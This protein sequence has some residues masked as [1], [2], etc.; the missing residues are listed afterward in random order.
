ME[1]QDSV[2]QILQ[3]TEA[4]ADQFYRH[5]LDAHP[6]V[7]RYFQGMD[8]KR[9]A[10]QLHMALLLAAHHYVHRYPA[11][12]SYLKVLGHTHAARRGV[13]VEAYDSFRDCLIETLAEFHGKDWDEQLATQWREA[14]DL[15]IA[16]MLEGYEGVHSV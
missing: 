1:I 8:L 10:I 7:L 4:V 15:A 9:Q 12:T 5:Y 6:E 11:T 3:S 14:L 16:T 13:P 2:H